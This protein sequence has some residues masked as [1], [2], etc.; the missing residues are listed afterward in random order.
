MDEEAKSFLEQMKEWFIDDSYDKDAQE[1]A[2][3]DIDKLKHMSYEK[4]CNIKEALYQWIDDS[5]EDHM[6]ALYK[7]RQF[8]AILEYV[9]DFSDVDEDFEEHLADYLKNHP[10]ENEDEYDL[11]SVVQ[12]CCD[13]YE[14]VGDALVNAAAEAIHENDTKMDE[15]EE[16]AIPKCAEHFGIS[17]N[18]LEYIR[19]NC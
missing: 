13:N 2:L 12:F 9:Y 14:G 4:I 16:L 3:K 19:R 10:E 6:E 1:T 15:Y 18:T 7:D 8:G 11:D 17:V 5:P